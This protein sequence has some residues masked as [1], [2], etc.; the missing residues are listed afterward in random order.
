MMSLLLSNFGQEHDS[1]VTLLCHIVFDRK[2]FTMIR[3]IDR[4]YACLNFNV[5]VWG[6]LKRSN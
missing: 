4:R 1:L 3:I 5:S 6:D 2:A